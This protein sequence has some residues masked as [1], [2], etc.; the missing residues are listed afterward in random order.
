MSE[1]PTPVFVFEDYGIPVG[2]TVINAL[3]SNLGS[4]VNEDVNSTIKTIL[5]TIWKGEKVTLGDSIEVPAEGP[6]P[7]RSNVVAFVQTVQE[8]KLLLGY[9][10]YRKVVTQQ[11]SVPHSRRGTKQVRLDQ[12]AMYD[13]AYIFAYSGES[14][15]SRCKAWKVINGAL[16]DSALLNKG[17]YIGDSFSICVLGWATYTTSGTTT[18]SFYLPKQSSLLE[19]MHMPVI[20]GTDEK[21]R[22]DT[23]STLYRCYYEITES[24][25]P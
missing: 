11:S 20:E 7:S 17:V 25:N 22:Y 13:S 5:Q 18:N 1:Q 8:G 14:Q 12:E 9:T 16:P 23:T 24:S 4:E 10:A 19:G 3:P 6:S 21:V 2:S 15:K